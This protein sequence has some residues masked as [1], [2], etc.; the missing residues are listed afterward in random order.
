MHTFYFSLPLLTCRKKWC[1]LIREREI[2]PHKRD[3]YQNW[4]TY[5]GIQSSV[6]STCLPPERTLC[7]LHAC[8]PWHSGINKKMTVAVCRNSYY[9]LLYEFV[10]ARKEMMNSDFQRH[11]PGNNVPAIGSILGSHFLGCLKSEMASKP[12]H[13]HPQWRQWYTATISTPPE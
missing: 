13:L 10:R 11:S 12:T 6:R 3:H 8:T 9:L 7:H 1:I 2:I 5:H 4:S